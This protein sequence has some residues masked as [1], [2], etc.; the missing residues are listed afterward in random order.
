M[1][2]DDFARFIEHLGLGEV[3][4]DVQ[5]Q[6]WQQEWVEAIL[7]GGR[8]TIRSPQRFPGKRQALDSLGASII[9][10][11]EPIHFLAPTR[12]EAEAARRRALAILDDLDRLDL[13]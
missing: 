8:V 6:P 1:T 7:A 12:E 4:L 11:G 13:S 10:S 9:A 3:G 2:G 5:L